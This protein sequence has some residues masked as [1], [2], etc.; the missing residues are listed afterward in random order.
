MIE[1]ISTSI[2]EETEFNRKSNKN[3]TKDDSEDVATNSILLCTQFFIRITFRVSVR[4][5]NTLPS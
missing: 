2:D 4:V 3:K 5:Y 1:N